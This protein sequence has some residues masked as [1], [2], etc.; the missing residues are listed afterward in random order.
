[1]DTGQLTIQRLRGFTLVELVTVMIIIGLIGAVA[2]PRVFDNQRFDNRGYYTEVINA[3]RYAQQLAVAINCNTQVAFIGNSYTVTLADNPATP[4]SCAAGPF[5]TP[6]P[7]PVTGQAG[8]STEPDNFPRSTTLP[9]ITAVPD[10]FIFNAL[11]QANFTVNVNIGDF[12][13]RVHQAT[14]YIEQLP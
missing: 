2:I 11:G 7:N 12:S 8:F 4:A 6:A 3:V 1:M 5:T 10:T 14:G 13:F 9:N